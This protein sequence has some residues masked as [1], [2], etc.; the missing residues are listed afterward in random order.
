MKKHVS[1]GF[2][3]AAVLVLAAAG[4]LTLRAGENTASPAKGPAAAPN[5]AAPKPAESSGAPAKQEVGEVSEIG[6]AAQPLP[7]M[8]APPAKPREKEKSAAPNAAAA[9]AL[10]EMP[11][12]PAEAGKDRTVPAETA[13]PLSA[14]EAR[15]RS[16]GELVNALVSEETEA[17]LDHLLRAVETAP[18]D[19]GAAL[20]HLENLCSKRAAALAALER[21]DALWERNPA[22]ARLAWSGCALHRAA[23]EDLRGARLLDRS[24]AALAEDP[25][26]DPGELFGLRLERLDFFERMQDFA[27]GRAY[28]AGLLP[29][30]GERAGRLL[31]AALDFHAVGALRTEGGR[32]PAADWINSALPCR[33]AHA[34]TLL[35]LRRRDAEVVSFAVCGD[36]IRLYQR[37]G[38]RDFALA[39]AEE[40][41]ERFPG[42]ASQLQICAAAAEAG[43]VKNCE[44]ML[45]VMP[46]GKYPEAITA[47][48]RFRA[49]LQAK[50]FKA[51]EAFLARPEAKT[52]RLRARLDLLAAR[53]EYPELLKAATAL[54]RRRRDGSEDGTVLNALLTAAERCSD[55]KALALARRLI[56][57]KNE[58]DPVFANA[59][60][61]IG[62]MIGGD[63]AEASRLVEI[64]LDDDPENAAYLDSL[65][66][67]RLKQG[68]LDEAEKLIRHA[69]RRADL[70]SGVAVLIEH[71][72]D[73]AA[74]RGDRAGALAGYR[75][76]LALADDD[77]AIDAEALKRK[78]AA[79]EG[80]KAE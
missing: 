12:L 30:A 54:A 25:G 47:T 70:G 69:L 5:A 38:R 78:I 39:L 60:G 6:R 75:G 72:A 51:A 79:L 32:R 52:I 9:P 34:E 68:K 7:E 33:R 17:K 43:D 23:G 45:C 24:L 15:T 40:F 80:K 22:S 55:L 56:G 16:L 50:D 18:F 53:H 36:R 20:I 26:C 29:G 19:S 21:F 71:A 2:R 49:R 66:C 48:L 27:G 74:A 35:A 64:A 10:P 59:I 65:A 73:I 76:A 28:I 62:V 42:P 3:L 61:Y 1:R 67:V 4:A 41:A 58:N 14:G 44:A 77:P 8:P 63:P 11:A 57:K 31:E 46:A 37:H 13:A